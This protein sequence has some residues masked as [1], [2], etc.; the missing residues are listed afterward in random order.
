MLSHRLNLRAAQAA[1]QGGAAE[2]SGEALVADPVRLVCILA[3]A[4]LE[5]LDVVGVVALEKDHFAVAFEGEHVRGDSIEEPAVVRDHD[6]RA[7]ETQ[8]CILERPESFDVEVVRRLIEQQQ[9][10]PRSQQLCKMHAVALT[11]RQ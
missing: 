3:L 10:A 1:W 6:S 9:I 4:A 5:I 8:Q 7:W 11:A 2:L